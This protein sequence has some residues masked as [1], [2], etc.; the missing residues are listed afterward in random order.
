MQVFTPAEADSLRRAGSILRECL[1]HVA[2]L[3][4]PG[5]TTEALDAIAE[6][7]ILARGG[8]PGFKGYRNY[9]ASLCI[10]V[11]DECVHG[12]PGKRKLAEGDIVSLDGGVM[13]DGLHTDACLTVPVGHISM[14]ARRLLDVTMEALKAGMAEVRPG[15]RIGDISAAVQHVVEDGGCTIIKPLTGHGLGRTLHQF[16]DIPNYGKRGSGPII[17]EGTLL[18]IEPIT[19]LGGE[20][21]RELD[22]GWTI[23]TADGALSAHFEHTVLVTPDGCEVIA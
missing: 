14:D 5:V 6:E 15:N 20:R 12:M 16:P 9:P 3:A 4:L 18:A 8:K 21:I 7:F 11:N 17:V 13:I 22:D 10:S 1:R 2:T 23:A 19:S